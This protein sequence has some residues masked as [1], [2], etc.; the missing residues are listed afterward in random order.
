MDHQQ[1]SL[2]MGAGVIACAL[3]LR[4]AA[5]GFFQPVVDF[6]AKPNIA[7]FLIYLET[8]RIVRFS[9]SSE[10]VPAFAYE[11]AVPDFARQAV[12]AAAVLETE[13]PL[14]AFEAAD[15]E[16]LQ[17]KNSAG[18]KF[19]ASQLLTSPLQ[20]D[21]AAQEPAVLILHTHGRCPLT[22]EWIKNCGIYTQ[23]NI[24]QP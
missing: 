23:W 6:L 1:W 22:D 5:T 14:P 11:S 21:L 24:T 15:A 17:F 2:R 13:P 10:D 8:G 3:M 7:S 18:V 20:W 19:D 16:I 4:L 12:D 9:P